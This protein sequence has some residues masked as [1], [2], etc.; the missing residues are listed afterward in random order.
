MRGKRQRQH[1]HVA[2]DPAGRKRQ[3]AGERDRHHEQIDQHE[4]ERKQPG[5]AAD[6]GFAVVLDHRDVELPRQQHDGEQ[7]QQRHGAE[8]CELR[9]RASARRRCCGCV[10]RA[11]EQR[12]RPVEHH[13]GDEDA[14]GEEGHQLDD[15]FRRDRQHQAVLVLGRID[16]A[17]AEQ[18]RE[19][20]HRQRDEQ[21]DVAEQRRRRAARR[22][23]APGWCETED[24]TA[25]SCSAM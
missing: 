1:E 15:R 21:R 2:V 20:R 9:A 25:L 14:D 18:H 17:G 6:L 13:E 10:E 16:V 22:G 7:R 8:R 3:Q 5:G 24:D 11:R 12:D 4:I 23:F 19:G